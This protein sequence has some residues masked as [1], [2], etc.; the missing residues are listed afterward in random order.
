MRVSVHFGSDVVCLN[1]EEIFHLED[2][3]DGEKIFLQPVFEI[4]HN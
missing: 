4:P 3:Q 1:P 2:L